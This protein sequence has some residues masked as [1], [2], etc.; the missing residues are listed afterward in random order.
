MTSSSRIVLVRHGP[1]AH[2]V[3]ERL[4]DR[5]G[6]ERWRQAYDTAGIVTDARP[7]AAVMQLATTATHLV[8]SDLPRAIESATRLAPLRDVQTSALL[9]E[10]PLRIP[11]WP[12]R[13]PFTL[14]GLVI[15]AA[16]LGD[17]AR[18]VDMADD[19]RRRA[20]AAGEWLETLA[21]SSHTVLAVTHGV[22]R[23]MLAESLIRRRWQQRSRRKSYRHWSVWEFAAHG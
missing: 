7:P 22:F 20:D 14:W 1:S 16:W 2:V 4:I 18:G 23:S 15:H 21:G 10:S 8:A 17:I 19:E 9:R 12:S 11:A 6:V 13:L 5:A 3:R